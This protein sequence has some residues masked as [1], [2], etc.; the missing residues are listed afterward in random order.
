MNTSKAAAQDD[1]GYKRPQLTL[2][3]TWQVT[4][5]PLNLRQKGQQV[6]T[7]NLMERSLCGI[8]RFPE[9]TGAQMSCRTH[10]VMGFRALHQ[11]VAQSSIRTAS[12]SLAT[13]VGPLQAATNTK[14]KEARP[15]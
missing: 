7:Q 4:T 2:D 10:P 11:H 9:R 13:V 1:A 3:E 5:R 15:Q 6:L 12:S 14:T 8:P